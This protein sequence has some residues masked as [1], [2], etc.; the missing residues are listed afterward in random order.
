MF[1]GYKPIINP[2]C[3]NHIFSVQTQSNQDELTN[4]KVLVD[5]DVYNYDNQKY[6]KELQ[7]V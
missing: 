2:T 5:F 7:N 6:M 1:G 4:L 3:R